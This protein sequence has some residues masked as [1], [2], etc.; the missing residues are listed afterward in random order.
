MPD[1][2]L[3]ARRFR[4]TQLVEP[5]AAIVI[6]T[7]LI[8]FHFV[9][10][11]PWWLVITLMLVF[12]TLHQPA[13]HVRM[14]GG[15]LSR[16]LWLRLGL[17]VSVMGL[18]SYAF[19]W[20]P[21]FA[22]GALLV[23][24]LHLGLSGSRAWLPP[25]LF[26]AIWTG[27][28]ETAVAM[29]WLRSYYPA[30]VVHVASGIGMVI[31]AL[32]SHAM[33]SE[34][35]RQES[36]EAELRRSEERFRALV[37]GSSDVTEVVDP[38]AVITYVSPAIER[39]MGYRAEDVVGTSLLD[40]LDPEDHAATQAM[41]RKVLAAPGSEQREEMRA[42]HVD[43]TWHWHETSARNLLDHPAVRGIVVNH[44]DITARRAVED[45]LA[46]Q[47]SHDPLTGVANRSAFLRALERAGTLAALGD[48]AIAVLFLDLD[49]FKQVN[50]ALGHA[51]GDELLA[52]VGA[53]LR[54]CVLGADLVGRLGADEFAVALTN[55]TSTDNMV[56]VA[57]RVLAEL[58][59][60]VAIGERLVRARASIGLA[61]S[62]PDCHGPMELLARAD[63]AM[64]H[65][66]RGGSGG[67]Q[68]Y[69]AGMSERVPTGEPTLED[70]LRLA[71]ERGELRLQ[72]QP[73]VALDS[74][75]LVG[76]EALV[77]WEHPTRGW[78]PPST[79]IPLA[80]ATGLIV[81]IGA[82]VLEEACRRVDGWHRRCPG[83]RKMTLSVN[84]SPRQLTDEALIDT[85]LDVLDRTGYDP[86]NLVLEVTESALVDYEASVPRLET[87]N[88]HGIRVAL[89]DFGTG[90]SSLRYLTRLPVN[91]LKLDQCFVAELNGTPEG[92][93]LAEAVVR[94]G[95][96]LHL[97][98][99][100]EGIE[101]AEQATELV[102]LGY[103]LGQG[104]HFSRPLHPD[105][106]EA[107]L[108]GAGGQLPVLPVPPPPAVAA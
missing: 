74:G 56:R 1:T 59:T 19:G 52:T 7:A 42:Q 16:R 87:L 22:I 68:V 54:R 93:A 10:E 12:Q 25:V 91:V 80:E 20:G 14:S 15:D 51:A 50:D 2:P 17:H 23:V 90:Y 26:T 69:A 67:Y 27:L 13:T 8:K 63:T 38:D 100:A 95:Q 11:A 98:T 6:C 107:L 48:Q 9:G 83:S 64:Y 88:K 75:R 5:I 47:A 40:R 18:M 36:A 29:G 46:Y 85:V 43:G 77:R 103:G 102:G 35:A 72:Y 62:G 84:L 55:I 39:V 108:A 44:R 94:L 86:A 65:A 49:G 73:V 81:P 89:D 66:K 76:V 41:L 57:K 28:G 61:M 4:R 34:T 96:S 71:A 24:S 106:I 30:G 99:V 21:L 45:R 33:G 82:W 105:D 32:C 78:M 101:H 58:E 97:E 70:D 37:Q 92:S 53:V 79:F 60:P 104:Y 31:M 3:A